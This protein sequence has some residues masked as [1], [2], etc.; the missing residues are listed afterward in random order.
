[1]HITPPSPLAQV[2]DGGTSL[3]GYTCPASTPPAQPS[4]FE[5]VSSAPSK[6][7]FPDSIVGL[8]TCLLQFNA[9]SRRTSGQPSLSSILFDPCAT[10]LLASENKLP[11]Y[12]KKNLKDN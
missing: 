7:P 10:K 12:D 8:T 4:T 3:L 5:Q 6:Q 2:S 9:W 1:M 11:V